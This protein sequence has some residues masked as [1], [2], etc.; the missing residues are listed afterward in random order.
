ME[1]ERDM[2]YEKIP[3]NRTGADSACLLG[4]I[5][6]TNECKEEKTGVSDLLL[7]KL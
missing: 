7:W 4:R 3:D 2:R 5:F 1:E 6:L